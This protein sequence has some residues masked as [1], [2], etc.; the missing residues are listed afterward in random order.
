MVDCHRLIEREDLLKVVNR[1]EGVKRGKAGREE[2]R[3]RE[4]FS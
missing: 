3:G 1:K 4:T 2:R